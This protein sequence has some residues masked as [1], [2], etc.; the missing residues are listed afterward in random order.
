LHCFGQS[1][2]ESQQCSINKLTLQ[3]KP[4]IHF[5]GSK[6]QG[7]EL[8]RGLTTALL[9]GGQPVQV[10]VPLATRKTQALLPLAPQA[11]AHRK[12]L[13]GFIRAASGQS[14]EHAS[15]LKSQAL[16]SSSSLPC[17][18]FHFVEQGSAAWHVLRSAHLFRAST[19]WD[20]LLA[21]LVPKGR[22]MGFQI[23]RH[24][25]GVQFGSITRLLWLLCAE[26]GQLFFLIH[27]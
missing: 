9:P 22:R 23:P 26:L 12:F 20:S 14:L 5:G 8:L 10:Y 2:L 1:H 27:A 3:F 19:L 17:S 16:V 15:L 18:L 21:S 25:C 11:V 7:A 24:R 4:N 6:E 13:E